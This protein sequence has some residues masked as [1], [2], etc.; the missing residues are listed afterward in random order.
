MCIGVLVG[1]E[2][3]LCTERM[4]GVLLVEVRVVVTVTIFAA[5]TEMVKTR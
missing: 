4:T 1:L 2:R 3:R 5:E